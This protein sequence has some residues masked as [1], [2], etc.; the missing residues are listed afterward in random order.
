KQLLPCL[1]MR[2]E[3]LVLQISR[4]HADAL[5]EADDLLCLG[6]I[7]AERLF[8]G[9]ALQRALAALHRGDDLLDVLDA[10]VVRAAEPDRVDR[11]I[12]DHFGYGAMGPG[13]AHAD[14]ARKFRRRRRVLRV[15]APHSANSGTAHAAPGEDVKARVEAGADEAYAESIRHC[16]ELEESDFSL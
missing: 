9:D 4:R 3:E 16:R 8:A 11:M 2:C 15:G 10:R 1:D 13:V 14:V 6:D 7:A 5:H 12:R